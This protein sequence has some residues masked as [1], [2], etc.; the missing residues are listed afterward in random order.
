MNPP[1]F[2]HLHRLQASA[3]AASRQCVVGALIRDSHGRVFIQKRS[4]DRPLFPGCWDIAGGH[5][6]PGETLL[7]ALRREVR[8]ETG[9]ELRR[10]LHLVEIFDW[11]TRREFDFVIE[12]E[13][14]LAQPRLEPQNFSAHRWIGPAELDLLKENRQPGDLALYQLVRR[15]LA[16]ELAPVPGAPPPRP[17]FTPLATPRLVLRRFRPSDLDAFLAYRND[18]KVARYQSWESTGAAEARFFIEQH[19]VAQPGLPGEGFQFAV[20]LQSTGCLVGDCYLLVYRHEPCQ[21]EIGYTLDRAHHGQGL[22]TEAVGRLLEYVF[23]D[24]GLHR[25][26]AITDVANTASVRLLERL[27]LRRE[28]HFIQNIWFKG[29]WGDEYLYAILQSEWLHSRR[30]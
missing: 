19:S 18:P 22:M 10:V 16:D 5:V 13:G 26:V 23:T 27:G 15:V 7:Q 25:V 8:E 2:D 11:D 30:T 21:A 9:W 29:Q 1:D 28:G 17:P 24:L 6:D 3:E 14:D 20:A 12:V 4:P